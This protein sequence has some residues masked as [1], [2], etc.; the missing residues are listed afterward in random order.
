MI[1]A[2]II[3]SIT[4]LLSL[5]FKLLILLLFLIV[6]IEI[7]PL[8][9]LL[10]RQFLFGLVEPPEAKQKLGGFLLVRGEG[11]G[12]LEGRGLGGRWGWRWVVGG[13]G[14]LKGGGFEQ[15]DVLEA[16]AQFHQVLLVC[17]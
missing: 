7:R 16:G 14:W 1:I 15:F 6:G 8:R 12:L 5:L 2:S 9:T 10:H 3:V 4:T 13:V 17:L 11:L